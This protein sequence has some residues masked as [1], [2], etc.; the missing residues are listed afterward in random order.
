[1]SKKEVKSTNDENAITGIDNIDLEATLSNSE[2][3]IN[4][5][6]SLLLGILGGIIL[7]CGSL[8]Y[9]IK[10]YVPERNE[11]AA[12]AMFRAERYFEVDSLDLALKGD[13]SNAGFLTIADDFGSTDPGRLAN[14][15]AGIIYMKKADFKNA[16][17]HL[18]NYSSK[19]PIVGAEAIGLVGDCYVEMEQFEKGLDK[20]KEAASHK[21][22]EATTPYFLFKAGQLAENMKKHSDAL[23]YYNRIKRDYPE[24]QTAQE[25]EKYIA[26]AEANTK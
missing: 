9:Y 13:G 18:E 11:E 20:Y 6:K 23:S 17:E 8:F 14:L 22:N 15:Y 5:N 3:F 4:K 2:E 1:M 16:I 10:M 21:P 19:D 24:S 12:N 25:I 26:R 7:V